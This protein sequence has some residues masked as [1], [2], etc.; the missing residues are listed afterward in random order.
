MAALDEKSTDDQRLR[1]SINKGDAFDFYHD[2]SWL[3]NNE[4][5]RYEIL[6]HFC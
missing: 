6:F 3:V 4:K 2:M 1:N 5:F